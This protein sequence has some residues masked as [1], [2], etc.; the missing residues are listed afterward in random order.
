MRTLAIVPVVSALMTLKTFMASMMQTSVSS[1]TEL[2]TL[3][4]GF[5]PCLGAAYY[6]PTIG[7]LI[8]ISFASAAAAAAAVASVA[9]PPDGAC[10]TPDGAA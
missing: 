5:S 9:E 8:G 6:V 7:L 10:G 4:H 2:P 1:L 3:T